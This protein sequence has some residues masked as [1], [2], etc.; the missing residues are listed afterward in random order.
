RRIWIRQVQIDRLSR[1]RNDH[2]EDDQKHQQHVDHRRDVGLVGEA[3]S[4]S[5]CR[6]RHYYFPPEP[7]I[8]RSLSTLE[9]VP[10]RWSVIIPV[11]VTPLCAAMSIASSTF[12]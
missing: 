1:K 4:P 12:P 3:A 10:T 8:M 5:S 7:E 11:T 6:H 9:T 2:H